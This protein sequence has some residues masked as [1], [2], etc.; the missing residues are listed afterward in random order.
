MFF[1]RAATSQVTASAQPAATPPLAAEPT[2]AAPPPATAAPAAAPAVAAATA[3]GAT[4]AAATT[5]SPELLAQCNKPKSKRPPKPLGPQLLAIGLLLVVIVIVVK[6]LPK[7]AVNHS[8]AFKR[9]RLLNWLPLGLTYGFLYMARYNINVYMDI[10]RITPAQ[11]GTMF[12]VGSLVYGL[13]FFLNGPLTDRWGGRATILI[14]AGGVAATNLIWGIME[15]TGNSLGDRVTNLT[16]LYA[17]N[18]YFQSFGAVSIVKVNASWFHVRERGTFGGIFGILIS[19]GVFLAYDGGRMITEYLPIPWLFFMPAL[20]LGIF[21]M[22]NYFLVF[23]RPS[24]AGYADIDTGDGDADADD[25]KPVNVGA[26]LTRVLTH[27]VIMT[28]AVIELFS[29]FLRQAIMQWSKEFSRGVGLE[30]SFVITNIGVVLCIAGIVG[31][32]FA[33]A[34]SDHLFKSRRGP[35]SAFLYG[36]VLIGAIAIV[37]LFNYR[38]AIPWVIAVMAMAIIGVHGM[39]TATMSQDFGGK[40]NTGIVVGVI[41]GFVYFGST[42]QSFFYGHFLPGKIPC[43]N[44]NNITDPAA[45]DINNWHVWPYAMIVVALLGFV[46]ALRLW[47][48]RPGKQSSSGH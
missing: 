48:V 25:G 31:G 16:V 6:R 41:D 3:T 2:A 32:M 22:I 35:V 36:L 7:S 12:G 37:P 26:V 8:A 23:D 10:E 43:P 27:P 28:V 30:N 15:L 19:L 1:S 5:L 44:G 20:L 29:G 18:M 46:L 17:V 21:F 24:E 47:N 11:F 14:S 45:K 13:S 38:P 40:R 33:G 34:V 42:L 4:S 39:L 9:R